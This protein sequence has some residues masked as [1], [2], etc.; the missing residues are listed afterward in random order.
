MAIIRNIIRRNFSKASLFD[1]VKNASEKIKKSPGECLFV[2]DKNKFLGMIT[3]SE[4]IGQ[5]PNRLVIDIPIRKV[6][7]ARI[8]LSVADAYELF[9]KADLKQLPVVDNKGNVIGA[10]LKDDLWL[11]YYKK[12]GNTEN[13]KT[14][15]Q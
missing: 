2:F 13:T 1:S 11:A 6:E 9:K 7:P 5:D 3:L 14:Q 12:H 15:E 10:L 4:L 8:D